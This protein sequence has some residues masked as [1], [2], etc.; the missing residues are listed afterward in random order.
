MS[1]LLVF[2]SLSAALRAGYHV[3][4]R[5]DRGYVVRTRTDAGYAMALVHCRIGEI[6]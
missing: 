2:D 6:R 1:G 4:D 3:Y 5:S